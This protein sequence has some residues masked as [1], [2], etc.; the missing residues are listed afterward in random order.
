MTEYF[1]TILN[2]ISGVLQMAYVPIL[3]QQIHEEEKM[4]ST[5]LRNL[6]IE[7]RLNNDYSRNA[8][9]VPFMK[10][11]F[12][13]QAA[14]SAGHY[15]P[16]GDEVSFLYMLIQSLIKR[17]DI[18]NLTNIKVIKKNK[19]V[20]FPSS[21]VKFL[22]FETK[23][24]YTDMDD[25]ERTAI[26]LHE[27]G[28]WITFSSL[29]K[30]VVFDSFA[31]YLERAFRTV[32]FSDILRNPATAVAAISVTH[33]LPLLLTIATI[34]LGVL[35]IFFVRQAEWKS[36]AFA[37][38]CGYAPELI[39]AFEKFSTVREY[40]NWIVKTGDYITKI[41]IF[42]QNYIDRVFPVFSHPSIK[43]RIA[44]LRDDVFYDNKLSEIEMAI[45]YEGW[46]TDKVKEKALDYVIKP[47]CK[48]VDR[49]VSYIM[50][51]A[52]FDPK[53]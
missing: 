31:N 34:L 7:V 33:E 39:S 49:M 16:F 28:H 46:F 1:P 37:K 42:V 36:D 21:D 5:R 8:W 35:T 38:H 10:S 27:V 14:T 30:A 25:G 26:L 40:A 48:N 20:I 18:K 22:A 43:R 17:K 51:K 12:H 50:K 29:R 19:T 44:A 53:G 32:S 24:L 47:M 4:L 23:G 9:T 15:V 3:S 52:I 45:L 2:Y 13:V 11:L 6:N 41:F